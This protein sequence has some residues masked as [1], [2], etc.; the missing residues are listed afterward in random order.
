MLLDD[1]PLFIVGGLAL[2]HGLFNSSPSQAFQAT[3]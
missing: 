1:V 2:H 3:N